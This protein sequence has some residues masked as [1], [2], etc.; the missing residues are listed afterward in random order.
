MTGRRRSS[1]PALFLTARSTSASRSST[2]III[3]FLLSIDHADIASHA[4][5]VAPCGIPAGDAQRPTFYLL[6]LGDDVALVAAG[7]NELD[8][9]VRCFVS[10]FA[11]RRHD[12]QPVDWNL[13]DIAVFG[14]NG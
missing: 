13:R 11:A 2:S 4:F 9:S 7:M 8:G 14:Q 12:C 10:A 5:E 6:D 3:P 1:V